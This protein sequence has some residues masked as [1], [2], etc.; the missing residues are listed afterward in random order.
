MASQQAQ[1]AQQSYN[2]T[3]NLACP[4]QYTRNSQALYQ[5]TPASVG[6][7]ASNQGVPE[8]QDRIMIVR[9]HSD[10]SVELLFPAENQPSSSPIQNPE[11][12]RQAKLGF[13][14]GIDWASLF[15]TAAEMMVD[16]GT[17][18]VFAAG[19]A[20]AKKM[21]IKGSTV[22]SPQRGAATG[23]DYHRGPNYQPSTNMGQQNR[24][25]VAPNVPEGQGIAYSGGGRP[26]SS[27]HPG[28]APARGTYAPPSSQYVPPGELISPRITVVG[29]QANT[30]F[31][32]SPN[33]N[34][35]AGASGYNQLTGLYNPTQQ[36]YRAPGQPQYNRNTAAVPQGDN[37]RGRQP[38]TNQFDMIPGGRG[39]QYQPF[40]IA[41]GQEYA[42]TSAAAAKVTNPQKLRASSPAGHVGKRP[43]G[44]PHV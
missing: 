20:G 42:S 9:T 39:Q 4:Q 32:R 29:Q 3:Q 6:I 31:E 36:S 17:D 21:L 27:S 12:D 23:Q 30:G 18:A 5:P 44:K 24:G 35:F 10:G 26:R 28:P 38:Y 40:G 25:Y 1:Q 14:Q 15:K 34:T 8:Y 33:R 11:E 43:G 37:V 19:V 16:K 7:P 2:P 41:T 22:R 13:W